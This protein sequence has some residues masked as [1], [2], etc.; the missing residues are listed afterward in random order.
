M[1]VVTKFKLLF[2]HPDGQIEENHKGV[3]REW[4]LVIPGLKQKILYKSTRNE[5]NGNTAK[6]SELKPQGTFNIPYDGFT[7][8]PK[9]VVLRILS[10]SKSIALGRVR[11][12]E[13]WVQWQARQLL[14]HR[15][16]HSNITYVIYIKYLRI[17][18]GHY[19]KIPSPLWTDKICL[20]TS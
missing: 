18:I 1:A 4:N 8:P 11:T 2:Q 13:P 3:G 7:S 12:F 10:P 16:R 6:I 17:R 15:E 5:H 9:E 19:D 14:H 20:Y